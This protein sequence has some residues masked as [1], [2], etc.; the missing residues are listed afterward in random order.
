MH[1]ALHGPAGAVGRACKGCGAGVG[2]TR[3][4]PRMGL[5]FQALK[6]GCLLD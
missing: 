5:L 6:A 1:R 4:S 3:A 2:G